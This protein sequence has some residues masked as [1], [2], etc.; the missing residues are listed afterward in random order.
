MWLSGKGSTCQAGDTGLITG[1]V[2]SLG[3]ENGNLLQYSCLGNWL[4]RGA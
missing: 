4:D 2:I 3:K 1:S